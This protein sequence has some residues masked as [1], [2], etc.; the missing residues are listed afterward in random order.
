[1]L[2][3][4]VWIHTK[5]PAVVQQ[6]FG[7]SGP[8][9]HEM[10][11]LFLDYIAKGSYPRWFTEG[12]AEYEENKFNGYYVHRP[13]QQ[14]PE[15]LAQGVYPLASM[16]RQFDSLSD[17]TLA[18]SQSLST[19]EYIMAVY[20]KDGLHKI[21]NNLAQGRSFDDSMLQALGTTPQQFESQW[22]AWLSRELNHPLCM[23][24]E[25]KV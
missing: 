18:Y 4:H 15:I 1:V 17:Q 23:K 8:M 6:I 7:Q 25:D 3:P 2:A 5:D 9:A 14:Q 11:H 10:T 24:Q 19:V 12:L 13:F 21:I 20:G 22:H 16:D